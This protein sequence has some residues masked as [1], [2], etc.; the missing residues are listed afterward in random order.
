MKIPAKA[1][2]VTGVALL[3]V[4]LVLLGWDVWL[5]TNEVEGDTISEVLAGAP[6]PVVLIA[7]Y[8]LGHFWPIKAVL[9]AAWAPPESGED[10]RDL[11]TDDPAE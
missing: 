5:A 1:S 8:L 6:L 2:T 9:R 4:F 3:A 7:G 11:P 10:N